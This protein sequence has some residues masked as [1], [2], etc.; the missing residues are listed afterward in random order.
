VA[1]ILLT[2]SEGFIAGRL[3]DAL[4]QSHHEL[5]TVD[6]KEG[7]GNHYRMD[8]RSR[9]FLKVV[10]EIKAEIVIHAAAQVSVLDSFQDVEM[11]LETNITATVKLLDSA[12]RNGCTNFVYIS[13][14][15]AIYDSSALLPLNEETRTNPQSPYG[16]SKLASESYVK[17]IC[18]QAG[19]DWSSLAL[20]NCYGPLSIH[21]KGVI[22]EFASAILRN[23]SAIIRGADVTRDFIHVDDVVRA[24]LLS[25]TNPTNCRVNI[26]SNTEVPLGVLYAK[27]ADALDSNLLPTFVE[28]IKG[29]V[30]RSRLDNGLAKKLLGWEPQLLFEQNLAD[31]VN[32]LKNGFTT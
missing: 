9:E 6:L 7:V 5:T 8:I 32:E 23:T 11:D 30:N 14:G 18:R 10:S 22:F 26:S 12:I 16:V 4:V 19:I 13:S 31:A 2:G 21:K 20:S 27:I 25:L 17:V 28:S 15:G 3:K 24:I 29:E 1:K